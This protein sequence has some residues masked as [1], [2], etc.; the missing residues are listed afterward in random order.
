MLASVYFLR[1]ALDASPAA[2]LIA[3]LVPKVGIADSS[4]IALA[5]SVLTSQLAFLKNYS[6]VSSILMRYLIAFY[7]TK[8]FYLTFKINSLT[9]DQLFRLTVK[10]IKFNY[11]T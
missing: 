10:K 6:S 7:S 9:W 3:V 11:Q 4:A 5:G 8:K 1:A 2:A